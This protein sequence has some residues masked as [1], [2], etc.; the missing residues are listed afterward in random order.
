MMYP[1]RLVSLNIAE[2]IDYL[3]QINDSPVEFVPSVFEEGKIENVRKWKDVNEISIKMFLNQQN[4]HYHVN[5]TNRKTE[6]DKIDKEWLDK[7]D[8]I[9]QSTK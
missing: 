6:M 4:N 1:D 7:I 2:E 9:R 8:W 5:Q 3:E